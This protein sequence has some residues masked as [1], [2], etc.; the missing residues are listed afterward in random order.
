M[1]SGPLLQVPSKQAVY[2]TGGDRYIRKADPAHCAI[3]GQ[4]GHSAAA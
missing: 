2:R 1:L 3:Y 4:G